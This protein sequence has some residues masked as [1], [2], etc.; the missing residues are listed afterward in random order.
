MVAGPALYV[1]RL[2]HRRFRPTPHAF[3]YG[4]FMVLVDVDRVA[5]QM[6]VSRLTSVNRFNWA[7]FDD[8]DH[9]GDPAR[10]LRERLAA[11][12]A[13]AGLALPD[14]PIR[15][16]THLRYL[17]YAF[18]PI[19]FYFC[20]DRDGTLRAVMGEVHNTFGGLCTYW[21]PVTDRTMTP[22]GVRLRTPKVMHVSPF[23]GMD[24]DYEFI[25]GAP[26]P[27]MV[28]HMNTIERAESGDRPYFDATLTLERRPWTA[29]A[30]RRALAR[31]PWMTAKV[32][33]AIH[34][35]ALRLWA[36][37]LPAYPHPDRDPER[38]TRHQ[39]G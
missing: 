33:G 31:H 6:A 34:W 24:V 18:N 2:R 20:H 27:S 3:S 19:S 25:V 30:I 11:D 36:K 15:L 13:R 7:S 16:L 39:E 4:L 26:G 10:P 21:L 14:G 38:R 32:I 9:L 8:R 17:G 22:R 5:E 12:A 35:E 28:A 1:G 37:R 29:A 23:M